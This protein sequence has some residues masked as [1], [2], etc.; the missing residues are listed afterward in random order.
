VLGNADGTLCSQVLTDADILC[1]ILVALDGVGISC[2]GIY[3]VLASVNI[4]GTLV[5]CRTILCRRPVLP[6]FN[7]VVL[8]QRIL[9]QP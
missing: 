8:Y 5:L 6:V 9:A 4:R 2:T 3:L 7:D 1:E